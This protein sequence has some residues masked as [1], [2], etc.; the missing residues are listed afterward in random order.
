MSVNTCV[1]DLKVF[2]LGE[3]CAGMSF[4]PLHTRVENYKL[5]SWES[6]YISGNLILI[7]EL[8]ENK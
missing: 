5:K 4:K 6:G 7:Q 2:I 1:K 3:M 8:A